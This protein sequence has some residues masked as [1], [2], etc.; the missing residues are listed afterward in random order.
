MDESLE[1]RV[2]N[3]R[4][5][6]DRHEREISR[7]LAAMVKLEK[8]QLSL[9]PQM[10]VEPDGELSDGYYQMRYNDAIE[11]AQWIREY[12]ESWGL[13]MTD[14]LTVEGVKM[15]GLQYAAQLALTQEQFTQ[16][17][18]LREFLVNLKESHPY[19]IPD[20]LLSIK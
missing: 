6:L 9:A 7:I 20:E 14:N 4:K 15:A 13:K 11:A 8:M 18:K 19:L 12:S 5:R 17:R 1:R 2:N 3:N 16:I 10:L